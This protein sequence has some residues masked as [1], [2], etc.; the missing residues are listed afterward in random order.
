[1]SKLGQSQPVCKYRKVAVGGTF[2]RLHRGHKA[3]LERAFSVG[4][5][6]L[7][8]VASDEMVE[9]KHTSA[10]R[11]ASFEERVA[12]LVSF[13][14]GRGWLSRARILK[15]E[16][17]EGVLLEDPSIEALVVSEETL[18]R[19][20]DINR[21]RVEKGLPPYELEVVDMVLAEDGRPISSSRIRAGEID[22]EGR[23]KSSRL[24]R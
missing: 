22:E 10:C 12:K 15:I 5:E 19:G 8:G 23:L 17:P 24:S 7:I 14:S 2:D 13:I 11:V 21:K 20:L 16:S 18:R 4:M 6:V 9:S 3:L 1:M